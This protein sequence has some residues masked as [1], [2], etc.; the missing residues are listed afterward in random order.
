MIQLGIYI[1]GLVANVKVIDAV[2]QVAQAI[3]DALV[4][5]HEAKNQQANS[6]N[7]LQG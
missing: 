1:R 3:L 5:I 2:Q 7:K 4:L 6:T